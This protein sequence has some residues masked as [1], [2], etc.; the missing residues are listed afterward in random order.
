MKKVLHFI[1]VGKLS[2]WMLKEEFYNPM[3][4]LIN[5]KDELAARRTLRRMDVMLAQSVISSRSA[6]CRRSNN[7]CGKGERKWL[8]TK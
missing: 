2:R 4:Q 8:I 3:N 1:E 6:L 5:R 7:G